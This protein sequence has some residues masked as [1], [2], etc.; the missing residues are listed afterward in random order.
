MFLL[1]QKSA[2]TAPTYAP[3]FEAL[4]IYECEYLYMNSTFKFFALLVVMIC[5]VAFY[6]YFPITKDRVVGKYEIDTSFYS[7]KNAEWQKEHFKFEITS[8]DKF[9]FFEKLAD[10]SFKKTYADLHWYR[11]SPPMLFR[12]NLNSPHELIDTYPGLY[13]GNRKFYYVFETKFG[14]MFY[15]KI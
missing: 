7:G 15:R 8:D 13:R 6:N 9:I 12:L 14:N 11:N 4:A 10:G 1:K 5:G 2:K 3:V